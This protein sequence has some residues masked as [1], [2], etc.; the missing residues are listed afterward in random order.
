MARYIENLNECTD[1]TTGDYLLIYDASAGA[2]DKDRKANI[3]KFAILANASTFSAQQTFSVSAGTIPV[4]I[5]T[6]ANQTQPGV[7]LNPINSGTG[8]GPYISIDRNNNGATPA[9]G[10]VSMAM[11]SGT[12]SAIWT[13][14]TGVVRVNTAAQPTNAN[15]TSGTVVGAQTSYVALKEDISEYNDHQSALDAIL[16]CRLFNYRFKADE[17]HRQYTGL[18]ITDDDRGAWFSE[19]DG[20]NQTPSLNERNLFGY[21][22]ASIQALQAQVN[23]LRQQVAA[24]T[25]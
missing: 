16:A 4:N 24:C 14:N 6:P 18:V 22:I 10:F 3:S 7:Y 8:V 11:R 15:D 17:S 25:T 2:T 12:F 21:L 20:D 19:N 1:P 23:E 13:D 9:A 5:V